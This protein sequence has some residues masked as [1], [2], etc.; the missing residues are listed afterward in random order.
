MFPLF[1]KINSLQCYA[2]IEGVKND[3]NIKDISYQNSFIKVNCSEYSTGKIEK[4]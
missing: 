2:D 4:V 3:I 1:E